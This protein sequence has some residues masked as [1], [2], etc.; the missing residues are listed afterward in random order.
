MHINA[1]SQNDYFL[2]ILK[3]DSSCSSGEISSSDDDAINDTD[4]DANNYDYNDYNHNHNYNHDV[5]L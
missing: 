3:D 4:A 2:Y 5:S 1:K